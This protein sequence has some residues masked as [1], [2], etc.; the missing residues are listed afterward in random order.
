MAPLISEVASLPGFTPSL[1]LTGQ[2][3]EMVDRLMRYFNL[4]ADDDLD[5]MRSGQSLVDITTRALTELSHSLERLQP[6]AVVVQGDT[7]TAF[8]GAMAG[9]YAGLPVVHLEAGLR[10]RNL[11]APFPEEA[12]RQL[13]GRI[14]DLHLAPTSAARANLLA[15]AIH[16]RSVLVTGNTVIDALK[17]HDTANGWADPSFAPL[18]SYSGRVLLVTA[19]RRESWG[20]PMRQIAAAV[21]DLTR[22]HEDL[23]VV[24]PMHRNPLVRA[25]LRSELDG[26]PRVICTEPA[27]YPDFVG[28]M[29]RAYIVLSDSG[30]VQEEAP[31]LGKPVL[32]LRNV[33]E[34]PEGIRAGTAKL[35]GTNRSRIVASV[36]ELLDDTAKYRAMAMAVNPYG[37]GHAGS[38][39]AKAIAHMFGQCDR[40]DEF[41]VERFSHDV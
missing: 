34:R 15:E 11:A 32:V 13:I 27:D 37:D 38:R 41:A 36:S 1:I 5:L 12:N 10:T 17:A 8:A 9:F 40:P 23:L 25:D 26:L 22:S 7:T 18:S 29:K 21:A 39:G 24:L 35:V 2:H 4:H 33:T 30:G 3:R 19:H 31:S 28:L 14:A 16:P 20:P 6:D